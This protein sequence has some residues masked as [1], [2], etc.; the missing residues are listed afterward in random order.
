[1]RITQ[2]LD[3]TPHGYFLIPLTYPEETEPYLKVRHLLI[4]EKSDKNIF[5]LPSK[6]PP[7]EIDV[8]GAHLTLSVE[9]QE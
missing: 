7:F 3:S 4:L 2:H 1:M 5:A 9:Y 6:L 8:L